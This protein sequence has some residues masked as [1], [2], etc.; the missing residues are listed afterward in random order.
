MLL[1]AVF[2]RKAPGNT[3]EIKDFSENEGGRAL[4][5]TW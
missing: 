5:A 4:H 2:D 3:L 1:A